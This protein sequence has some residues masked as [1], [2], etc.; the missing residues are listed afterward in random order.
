MNGIFTQLRVCIF[1]FVYAD[2]IVL[3]A[4]IKHAGRPVEK[5][6]LSGSACS[7]LD[8]S[9]LFRAGPQVSNCHR[10]SAVLPTSV[11]AIIACWLLRLPSERFSA[12][13][14]G[15]QIDRS[16]SFRQH[17]DEVKSSCS[18]RFRV[19]ATIINSWITYGLVLTCFAGPQAWEKL[20]P[21]YNTAIRITSGLLPSTPGV[22]A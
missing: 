5:A 18:T 13:V 22:A 6:G 11:A 10:R 2:D 8:L 17:F 21:T 12:R 14:L 16:L 19:A 1:I 4:A 9:Q 7:E 15:I 20:A 3:M